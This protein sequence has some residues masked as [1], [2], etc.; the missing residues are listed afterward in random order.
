M[1]K[2][3][4]R[5]ADI[6]LSYCAFILNVSVNEEIANGYFRFPPCIDR[7]VIDALKIAMEQL[8]EAAVKEKLLD[9]LRNHFTCQYH[10]KEAAFHNP[11]MHWFLLRCSDRREGTWF[12]LANQM[13]SIIA[14]M[15][16]AIRGCILVLMQ[17]LVDAG[18]TQEESYRSYLQ[19]ARQSTSCAFAK[20]HDQYGYLSALA[21]VQ[22]LPERLF[23]D[24]ACPES[25]EIDGKY[26]D[27]TLMER[28]I[29]RI[30]AAV[31]DKVNELLL[32]HTCL[33]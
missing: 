18:N 26:I 27:T 8:D 10:L 24:P 20:L 28:A 13:T 23:I 3:R 12:I 29:K 16:Y 1:Q 6:L 33:H 30:I 9:M 31:K 4:E 25:V 14:Q 7:S 11:I 15:L 5:Y 17:P 32:G 21:R 22:E 2:T 19:F